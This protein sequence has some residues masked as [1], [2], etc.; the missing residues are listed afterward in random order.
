M[1]KPK[2]FAMEIKNITEWDMAAII[3]A[4]ESYQVEFKR[5]VNSD[6]SKEIVAFAN[7]S[8]GRIFIGIEDDGTIQGITVTNK[9]YRCT[10]GFYIRSGA[11]CAKFS[12]QEI[13]EFIKS[14]GKLRFE[15][16]IT[17]SAAYPVILDERT[18]S[19]YFQLAGT[20]GVI[21]TEEFWSRALS[22]RSSSP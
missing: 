14:E 19:R 16:L 20:S 17:T 2:E 13:I 21:G 9:P 15:E 12:T 8:G 10:N 3:Q 22:F 18:V 5:N 6:I 4:G 7:S 11:S 1:Q